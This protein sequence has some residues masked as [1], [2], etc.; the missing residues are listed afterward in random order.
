MASLILKLPFFD[1]IHRSI[2]EP[3]RGI[4]GTVIVVEVNHRD[5]KASVPKYNMI[6]RPGVVIIDIPGV[7]WLQHRV[8]IYERIDE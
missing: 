5:H 8:K 1:H 7:I 3:V 4:D 6:G 2:H